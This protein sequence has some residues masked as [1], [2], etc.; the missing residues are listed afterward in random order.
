MVLV[1]ATIVA[2]GRFCPGDQGPAWHIRT[3]LDGPY[4]TPDRGWGQKNTNQQET[5]DGARGS[6]AVRA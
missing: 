1:W 5:A 6:E 4:R 3:L 2:A